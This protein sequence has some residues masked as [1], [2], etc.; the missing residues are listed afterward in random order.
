MI[1][2]GH[3]RRHYAIP[4][5]LSIAQRAPIWFS[6]ETLEALV[7]DA[8]LLH[9]F[10]TDDITLEEYFEAYEKSLDLIDPR[11][12]PDGATLLCWEQNPVV[13]HR[14]IVAIWLRAHGCEV[15]ERR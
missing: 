1:W 11:V 5:A 3:F 8:R 12:V 10:H 15:E 13:C 14:S 4:G 9:A 2:T 6:G 7:P